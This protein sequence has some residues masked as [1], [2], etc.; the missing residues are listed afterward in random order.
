M[1]CNNNTTNT[2]NPKPTRL[3]QVSRQEIRQ[4]PDYPTTEGNPRKTMTIFDADKTKTTTMMRTP[5]TWKRM[6]TQPDLME[7]DHAVADLV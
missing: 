4:L 2:N 3:R 1:I 7:E 6:T 5:R